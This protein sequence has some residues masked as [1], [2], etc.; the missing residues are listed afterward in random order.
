MHWIYLSPHFDD[1]VYSCGGLIRQQTLDGD[2]VQIWTINGGDPPAGGFSA[3]ASELHARWGLGPEVVRLRQAEDRAACSIVHAEA[4]HLP[5]PDCIYRPGGGEYYYAAEEAIFGPVDEREE[6][7]IEKLAEYLRRNVPAGAALAGPLALGGHVDHRLVRAAA[8]RSGLNLHYYLDYPYV[9]REAALLQSLRN[10]G[11]QVLA[12]PLS[13]EALSAWQDAT[14][15]YASQLS[16][17][18]ADLD[19]MRLAISAYS[20]FLGGAQLWRAPEAPYSTHT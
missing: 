16:S 7:L 18:W 6:P 2:R 1:A 10:Q 5:Q 17:F 15:A 14:A 11:W 13:P 3:F 9:V 4:L 19:G 8:E 20:Q 12:Y